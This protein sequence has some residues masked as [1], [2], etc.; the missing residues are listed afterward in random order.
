MKYSYIHDAFWFLILSCKCLSYHAYHSVTLWICLTIYH[1]LFHHISA[2]FSHLLNVENLKC[3]R[4][5]SAPMTECGM[6]Q[7]WPL[8]LFQEC[9]ADEGTSCLFQTLEAVHFHY[10]EKDPKKHPSSW[11]VKINVRSSKAKGKKRETNFHSFHVLKDFSNYLLSTWLFTRNKVFLLSW[12]EQKYIY[13]C[14]LLGENECTEE[15]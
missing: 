4:L 5:W 8:T 12:K 6:G 1:K 13:I 9:K 2:K 14:S 3:A 10:T 7:L 11:T 15:N